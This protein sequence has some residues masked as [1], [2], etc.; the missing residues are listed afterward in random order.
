[1]K[2]FRL[3][4]QH[5]DMKPGTVVYKVGMFKGVYSI[6]PDNMENNLRIIPDEKLEEIVWAFDIGCKKCGL[7]M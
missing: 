5:Y 6:D 3:I 4:K 2:K 1:M 7:D